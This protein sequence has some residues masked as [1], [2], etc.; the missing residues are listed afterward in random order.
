MSFIGASE[1][2]ANFVGVG[3]ERYCL[4]PRC[5]L[6]NPML[7]EFERI[8]SSAESS[9]QG[10]TSSVLSE[11][12]APGTITLELLPFDVLEQVAYHCYIASLHAFDSGRV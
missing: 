1:T 12:T 7:Q 6:S 5:C 4:T 9:R 11:P 3:E 2:N 10:T 8:E